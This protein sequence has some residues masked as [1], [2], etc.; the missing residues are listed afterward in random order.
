MDAD[1]IFLDILVSDQYKDYNEVVI[2]VNKKA[3]LVKIP[4]ENI[5]AYANA[6][7]K[8]SIRT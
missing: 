6:Q 5:K 7:G 1:K 4:L 2:M 3:F 8:L